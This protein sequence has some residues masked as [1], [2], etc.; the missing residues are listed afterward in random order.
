MEEQTDLDCGGEYPTVD[1]GVHARDGLSSASE[2]E[3]TTESENE[4]AS[5][6]AVNCLESSDYTGDGT[7]G[8]DR[9]SPDVS[10]L[11]CYCNAALVQ[12]AW[13]LAAQ[14]AVM[15]LEALVTPS[16]DS[17]SGEAACCTATE[18]VSAR[19]MDDDQAAMEIQEHC[20]HHWN[21]PLRF[22]AELCDRECIRIY[23]SLVRESISRNAFVVV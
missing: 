20:P 19:V 3:T 23:S 6:I 12:L 1:R 2:P 8:K 17:S 11:Q 4:G 10:L 13:K 15:Y 14:D 7:L 21:K 22:D 5:A 9:V 16:D 18:C